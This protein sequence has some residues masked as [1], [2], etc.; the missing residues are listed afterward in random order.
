MSGVEAAVLNLLETVCAFS[1]D[2]GDHGGARISITWHTVT[3]ES[4]L[5]KNHGDWEPKHVGPIH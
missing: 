3:H 1:A 5:Q 2:G 4:D